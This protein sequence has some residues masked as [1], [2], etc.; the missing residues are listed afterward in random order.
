[1]R[2]HRPIRIF[3]EVSGAAANIN[4]QSLTVKEIVSRLD[5]ERFIVMMNSHGPV[6]DRLLARANTTF[7]Q[8]TS[9]GTAARLMMKCLHFRP[10]IYFYPLASPFNEVYLQMHR[11]LNL[12]SKIV[13]HVVGTMSLRGQVRHN[14]FG[15]DSVYKAIAQADAVFG[16]SNAVAQDVS[17]VFHVKAGT[18]HN[19]VD[20][21]FF[22]PATV[23]SNRMRL[24]VLY[25]GSYRPYKRAQE[26]IKQ[27][28]RHPETDFRLIGEGE[29]KQNCIQLAK[30]LKC[31]N[32]E[33]VGNVPPAQ[34]GHAM[35]ESDLF[36]FPSVVEGHPQV[37]I[38]AAACGLPCIARDCYRPDSV[39]HNQTGF[40]ASDETKFG[41]HLDALI[42]DTRLRSQFGA[43]AIEHAKQFDWDRSAQK[44]A[45]VFTSLVDGSGTGT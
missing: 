9:H 37:L 12:K 4:A 30:E 2:N 14:W 6:D 10:D 39:V 7:V 26:V 31:T 25:V 34:V 41:E 35:R 43:A 18:I 33:F 22:Y 40:I 17:N 45:D 42:A 21:R 8:A 16:N 28:V 24:R 5:P 23:P 27:A 15:G 3:T 11:A 19:G 29:E 1:M 32:V 36:L 13:V 20:R 38:Q 44:W